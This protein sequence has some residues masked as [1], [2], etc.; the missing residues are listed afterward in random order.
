MKKNL[1][2][3]LCIVAHAYN[4]KAISVAITALVSVN[5]DIS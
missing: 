5:N 3:N 1:Y 4:Y 2:L